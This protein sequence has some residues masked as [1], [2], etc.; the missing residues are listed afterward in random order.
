MIPSEEKTL[1]K[2]DKEPKYRIR[3][4]PEKENPNYVTERVF[5]NGV[6]YQ[7]PV[8]EEVE[9]SKTVYDILIDRGII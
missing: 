5:V 1:E 2:L 7:I 9:V 3:I 6:C 4:K 8:G